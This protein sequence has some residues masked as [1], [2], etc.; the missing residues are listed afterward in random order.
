MQQVQ[1]WR[2]SGRVFPVRLSSRTVVSGAKLV[3]KLDQPRPRAH[4]GGCRFEI[5]RIGGGMGGKR[6]KVPS[7]EADTTSGKFAHGPVRSIHMPP[8]LR[9]ALGEP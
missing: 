9:E 2:R 7:A 6:R 1:R 4:R 3:Q 8:A 5:I